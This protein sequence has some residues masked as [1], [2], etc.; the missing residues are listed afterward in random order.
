MLHFVMAFFLLNMQLFSFVYA[1]EALGEVHNVK[2]ENTIKNLEQIVQ[3]SEQYIERKFQ[4]SLDYK[5]QRRLLDSLTKIY[6]SKKDKKFINTLKSKTPN[7]VSKIQ[8]KV[9]PHD[10][11][12]VLSAKGIPAA[13]KIKSVNPD[14]GIYTINGQKYV[15]SPFVNT[16][17]EDDYNYVSKAIFAPNEV[18][19]SASSFLE[20]VVL[21]SAQANASTYASIAVGVII[22]ALLIVKFG[23]MAMIAP[24]IAGA[25]GV[26]AL[27]TH[28]TEKSRI[29]GK[30]AK[31]ATDKNKD[32]VDKL[33]KKCKF[34]HL[35]S[36][37]K[38]IKDQLIKEKIAS[39]GMLDSIINVWNKKF[40][41]KYVEN[42]ELVNSCEDFAA[43]LFGRASKG[44]S[45]CINQQDMKQLCKFVA[46]AN[47][48]NDT[49]RKNFASGS[50]TDK[51]YTGMKPKKTNQNQK[52]GA[53][54]HPPASS[55]DR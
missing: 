30:C 24:F 49:F 44:L 20:N 11:T 14:L 42:V 35:K 17:L 43:T 51:V 6:Q 10:N 47:Q 32:L 26:T 55:S 21:S 28:L 4:L 45:Q 50:N 8:L 39:K 34:K 5:K 23:A 1:G 53:S 2:E 16:Y 36:S 7:V 9:I 19:N 48:C 54:Q 18:K 46:Y 3:K 22:A 41:P 37:F 27:V 13:I 15:V 38:S 12:I 40:D 33:R 29:N 52:G 31:R 25:L